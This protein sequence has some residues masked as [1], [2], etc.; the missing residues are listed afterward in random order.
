MEKKENPYTS[1]IIKK[2]QKKDLEKI[3]RLRGFL[4]YKELFNWIIEYHRLKGHL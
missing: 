4:T 3:L 2:E 1:L